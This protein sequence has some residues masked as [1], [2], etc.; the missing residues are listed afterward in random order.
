[1][2]RLLKNPAP[3]NHRR[4]RQKQQ[5]IK[6]PLKEGVCWWV[7]HVAKV[8]GLAV[9]SCHTVHSVEHVGS[10]CVWYCM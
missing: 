10:V 6:N 3:L 4:E 8:T 7:W 9:A 5:K 2:L 1:M